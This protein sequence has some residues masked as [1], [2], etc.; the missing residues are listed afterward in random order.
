[1]LWSSTTCKR[2]KITGEKV[3]EWATQCSAF[4]QTFVF[5]TPQVFV[6]MQFDPGMEYRPDWGVTKSLPPVGPTGGRIQRGATAIPH[7]QPKDD[8]S[9]LLLCSALTDGPYSYIWN[10]KKKTNPIRMEISSCPFL[11]ERKKV[12]IRFS[13]KQ[14]ISLLCLISYENF[15]WK[16]MCVFALFDHAFAAS[17]SIFDEIMLVWAKQLN[18][19]QITTSWRTKRMLKQ[20][21]ETSQ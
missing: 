11:L 14:I 13:M 15:W 6:L 17:C 3:K 21:V 10:M 1:M 19:L 4:I 2:L 12:I 8:K 18:Y 5:L 7:P 20:H 16:K 9:W